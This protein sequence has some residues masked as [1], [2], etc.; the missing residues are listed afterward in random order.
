MLK[1]EVYFQ[2]KFLE[3]VLLSQRVNAYIVLQ[4][5]S[6]FPPQALYHFAFPPMITRI[7]TALPMECTVKYLKFC[8]FYKDWYLNVVL[9]YIYN[10]MSEPEHLSVF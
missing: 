3:L 1:V 2:D 7:I 10:I 8:Q 4:D 9:I 5:I 6:K